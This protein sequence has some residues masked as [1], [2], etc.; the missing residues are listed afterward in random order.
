MC[1]VS[2][3]AE[4]WTRRNPQYNVPNFTFTSDAV[5]KAE[6]DELKRELESLKKLL[7][8]AK[9]YDKETGQPD[10]EDSEKIAL[11]K[12]LANLCGIDYVD[13]FPE[14]K[15]RKKVRA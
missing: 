5:S 4:D 11:F 3:V 7:T 10:C 8:A 6:F 14:K 13:I 15:K 9:V 2:Y 1:T 12:K